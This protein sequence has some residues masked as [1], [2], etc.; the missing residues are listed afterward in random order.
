[1]DITKGFVT[2]AVGHERYYKLAAN[3]LKSY[4][5]RTN[6]HYPFAIFAD[7][8]N[9]YTRMF[10]KVII[11]EQPSYSYNDKLQMLN[12]P[13]FTHNIFIDADCIVYGD[14]NTYWEHYIGNIQYTCGVRCFGKSLPTTSTEGWFNINDI[15]EYKDKITFIPQMHGGIIFFTDDHITKK[16]YNLS[17]CIAENYSKYKFKYFNSPADEPILALCMAINNIHPIELSSS[18]SEKAFC[19]YPTVCKIRTTNTHRCLLDVSPDGNRWI[20]NVKLLHWQN[21]NTQKPIYRIE[22]AKLS[23]NYNFILA[24]L[25]YFYHSS[26]FLNNQ[27]HRIIRKIKQVCH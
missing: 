4:K 26:Y 16:I 7:R 8:Q 12:N 9:E 27:I 24:I 22:V 20:S 15:G 3:L 17:Q 25:Y 5:L 18:E 1:M 19:F 14:I 11:L 23:I 2:L 10:D 13:P 21:V 6:E